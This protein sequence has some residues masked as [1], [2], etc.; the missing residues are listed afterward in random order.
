M[1]PGGGGEEGGGNGDGRSADGAVRG[2][3]PAKMGRRVVRQRSVGR[4]NSERTEHSAVCLLFMRSMRSLAMI[5]R[6]DESSRGYTR[7]RSTRATSAATE[8]S[9]GYCKEEPTGAPVELASMCRLIRSTDRRTDGRTVRQTDEQVKR[10][11]DEQ[12]KRSTD[13]PTDRPTDRPTAG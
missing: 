12:V 5:S 10:S 6:E 3:S 9:G 2:A 11:T 1:Y 7:C 13:A 4:L 8:F